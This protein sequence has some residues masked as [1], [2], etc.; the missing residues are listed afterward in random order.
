MEVKTEENKFTYIHDYEVL[1]C[2]CDPFSNLRMASLCIFMQEI[3]WLHSDKMSIGWKSLME[4][5]NCFWALTRLKVKMI[6]PPQWGDILTIKTWSRGTDGIQFFRDWEVCDNTG[7]IRA[8]G[9]SVWIVMNAET[10]RVQR[11]AEL[12]KKFPLHGTQVFPEKLKKIKPLTNPELSDYSVIRYS[13]LDVNCHMNNVSYLTRFLD[14]E[15]SG[16]RSKYRISEA[17]LN[18]LQ[19]TTGGTWVRVG[20]E[21]SG[22]T[23]RYTIYRRRDDAELCRGKVLWIPRDEKHGDDSS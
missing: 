5:Y 14:E 4:N 8:V 13:E 19:E 11:D 3:A 18:F 9:S 2:H 17:E 21:S 22:D 16:F 15:T 23:K 10:R 1:S 6:D 20:K 7:K 12:T